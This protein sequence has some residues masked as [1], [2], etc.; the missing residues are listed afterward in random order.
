MSQKLSRNTLIPMPSNSQLAA[1]NP[2]CCTGQFQLQLNIE[3]SVA[4][5]ENGRE[6]KKI[7]N[8]TFHKGVFVESCG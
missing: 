6:L 2:R 4:E 7:P 8:Q 5:K 1:V 3:L